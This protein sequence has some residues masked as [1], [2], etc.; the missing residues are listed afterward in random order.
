MARSN[1]LSTMADDRGLQRRLRS[2]AF[3]SAKQSLPPIWPGDTVSGPAYG[4]ARAEDCGVTYH[5]AEALRPKVLIKSHASTK[6]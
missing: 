4:H 1:L 5:N 2:N 6:E 3:N